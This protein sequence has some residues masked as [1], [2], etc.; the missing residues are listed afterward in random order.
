MT[1]KRFDPVL[2]SQNDPTAREKIKAIFDGSEYK[3]VDNSKKMG[4]DLFLYKDGKHLLNIEAEKKLV[5]KT[6]KF[7]YE[8]VQIPERKSK[9][10]KL[11]KPTIFVVIN[12]DQSSYLVIKGEDLQN[13]PLKEVPNRY[14]WKGEQFFQVP[15]SKV[16][17][18]NLLEVVKE[19]LGD[20]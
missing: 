18:D 20:V 13:S 6:A 2:H 1:R 3:V 10:F 16:S 14:V 7:P 9:Y 11:D 15:M 4:V 8:S 12:A 19:M 5:W 17:F